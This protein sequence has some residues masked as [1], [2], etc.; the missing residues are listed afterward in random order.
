[1]PYLECR[2]RQLGLSQKALGD[3]VGIRQNWISY[4][5]IGKALPTA[6]ERQRLSRVL[7][8][9]VDKLLQQVPDDL[10]DLPAVR[11]VLTEQRA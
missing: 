9:P 7:S 5:E 2:R 1:M 4:T 8:I 11:P 6:E 10:L 3:L